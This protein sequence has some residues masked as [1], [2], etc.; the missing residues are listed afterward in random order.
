MAN[1]YMLP[2]G[3][4]ATAMRAA[5][6]TEDTILFSDGAGLCRESG[7]EP[8]DWCTGEAASVIMRDHGR[9]DTVRDDVIFMYP[10]D[11]SARNTGRPEKRPRGNEYTAGNDLPDYYAARPARGRAYNISLFTQTCPQS[12]PALIH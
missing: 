5:A 4:Y 8:E 9:P 7:P 12:L 10:L 6:F 11:K 2:K 3:V 1:R